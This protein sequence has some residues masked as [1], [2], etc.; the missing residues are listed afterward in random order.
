MRFIKVQGSLLGSQIKKKI[1]KIKAKEIDPNVCKATGNGGH[2]SSEDQM[3]RLHMA[4]IFYNHEEGL[5]SW[6]STVNGSTA[7]T[8]PEWLTLNLS[9]N[10]SIFKRQ[11]QYSLMG[12]TVAL[13]MCRLEEFSQ[14]EIRLLHYGALKGKWHVF[15]S[16]TLV[17]EDTWQY[18]LNNTVTSLRAFS[19]SLWR[20]L[21][22]PNSQT[23]SK[24]QKQLL[25]RHPSI[26][27]QFL[28]DL[29]TN[30][31]WGKSDVTFLRVTENMLR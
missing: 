10:P 6:P 9:M 30:W 24:S 20:W 17:L 23:A 16:I 19:A 22:R 11:W 8:T 4:V 21:P 12:L 26:A 1:N 7:E 5:R 13:I 27:L 18:G 29:H 3:C 15:Y 25:L 2:S 14:V 31:S 28:T